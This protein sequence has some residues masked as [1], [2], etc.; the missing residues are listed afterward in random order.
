MTV[1]EWHYLHLS[2]WMVRA[3]CLVAGVIL[4]VENIGKVAGIDISQEDFEKIS[5]NRAKKKYF[6][7][8]LQ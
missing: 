6:K 4:I 2:L 1:L 5:T 8:N 3:L 7:S